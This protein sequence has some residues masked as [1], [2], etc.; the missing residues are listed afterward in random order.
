MTGDSEISFGMRPLALTDS[1]FGGNFMVV[2]GTTAT[3]RPTNFP[4]QPKSADNGKVLTVK[5]GY[6][7]WETA[8][9]ATPVVEGTLHDGSIT[10][11]EAQT[12]SFII[13]N[14]D[15]GYFYVNNIGGTYSAISPVGKDNDGNNQLALF[16]GDGTNLTLEVVPLGGGTSGGVIESLPFPQTIN[17]EKGY[18]LLSPIIDAGEIVYAGNAVTDNNLGNFRLMLGLSSNVVPSAQGE[19]EYCNFD[20]IVKDMGI[21]RMS[22]KKDSNNIPQFKSFTTWLPP[23]T[24]ADEGKSLV[25][26]NGNGQWSTIDTSNYGKLDALSSNDWNSSNVF[27][28]ATTLHSP[29]S[30]GGISSDGGGDQILIDQD[31]SEHFGSLFKRVTGFV[32]TYQ[33]PTSVAFEALG[34]INENAF[35]DLS[36]ASVL[37]FVS[38]TGKSQWIEP[39][40]NTKYNYQLPK[41]SGTIA[42]TSDLSEAGTSV[43]IRRW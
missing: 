36:K 19:Q 20:C 4:P 32:S 11:P 24:A 5:N 22:L 42:L 37:S 27:R 35:G 41:K 8:G 15:M 39:S 26:K 6:P 18:N 23:I 17:S 29:T 21:G 28:G 34:F 33:T 10:L 9:G 25:V 1:F 38:M 40:T 2:S 16:S 13:H 14:E 7:S 43:T 3:Q 31:L 12:T 30:V